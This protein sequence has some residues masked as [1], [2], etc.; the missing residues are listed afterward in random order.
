MASVDHG[1]LV[2]EA[3]PVELLLLPLLGSGLAIG[4]HFLEK[5]ERL[6]RAHHRS[7]VNT[8]ECSS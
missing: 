2:P 6:E 3:T 1:E 4:R 7:V 5:I 8:V